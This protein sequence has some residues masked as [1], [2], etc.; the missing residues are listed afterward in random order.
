M[1]IHTPSDVSLDVQITSLRLA[2]RA[3]ANKQC[4][5]LINKTAFHSFRHIH[6]QMFIHEATSCDETH[7]TH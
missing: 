3:F 6:R 1:E 7:H 2:S 4:N 5:R